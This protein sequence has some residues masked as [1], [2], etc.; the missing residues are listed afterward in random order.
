MLAERRPGIARMLASLV[1]DTLG[2]AHI[3]HKIEDML[4]ACMRAIACG[5]P[6]GT[7]FQF[8]DPIPPLGLVFAQACR[9]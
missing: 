2:P 6:G 5:Y 8:C 3:T 1:S 4:K 9:A 7:D